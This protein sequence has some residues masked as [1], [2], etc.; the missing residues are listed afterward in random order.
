[1]ELPYDS[2]GINIS[3]AVIMVFLF[4]VVGLALWFVMIYNRLVNLRN[5]INESWSDVDTE[6]KRRHDL[7]PNVVEAVKGYATHE[8]ELFETIAEARSRAI[9]A[10]GDQSRVTQDE[11]ELT[12]SMRQLMAVAESYP[13]LKADQNFLRLQHELVNTEDR[14]QA[15]RRF[16]NGN[17]R[18]Y[19]TL[20]QSFPS[21]LIAQRFGFGPR[22]YFDIED[23]VAKAVAVA[24][25]KTP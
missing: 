19:N 17:I 9:A 18:E 25:E 21:N 5:T 20:A 4:A 11:N 14:I 2:P 12:R 13:D 3:P 8:R 23:A 10:V 6:L 16:Y 22:N 24:F 15:A 1:V 7:I